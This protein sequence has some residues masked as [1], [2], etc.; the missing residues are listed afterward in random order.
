MLDFRQVQYFLALYEERNMT[1]AART[2]NI[3]QPAL[4]MQLA[5]LEDTVGQKLFERTSQGMVPTAAGRQLF[6]SFRPIMQAYWEASSQSLPQEGDLQGEV[7]IGMI[8]S[9]A[10]GMLA[11]ALLAFSRVHPRVSVNVAYNYSNILIDRVN[12]GKI[13]AAILNVSHTDSSLSLTQIVDDDMRL[14]VGLAFQPELPEVIEFA[15]IA[16]LDLALP[17]KDSGMRII[18]EDFA[19]Q[20]GVE[21]KPIHE[22][23]S[24]NTLLTLVE[25]SGF[26]TI[27]PAIAM[28]DRIR[29][30]AGIRC[31]RIVR[32]AIMRRIVCVTPSRKPLSPAAAAFLPFLFQG[33]RDL[34]QVMND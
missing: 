12:E 30:G 18:L 15:D 3:V 16:Q 7:S 11:D 6:A 1:S 5:K 17:T 34:Q 27:L 2:L 20:H 22:C 26:A 8:L 19:K 32:P 24:I 21:I 9:V 10:D 29:N 14:A 33:I 4:S 28:S 23:D 13:D 31:H 25:N